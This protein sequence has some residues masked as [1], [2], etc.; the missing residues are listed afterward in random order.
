M[1]PALK[2]PEILPVDLLLFKEQVSK[3][4][5]TL[6]PFK[7]LDFFHALDDS[8]LKALLS[9]IGL[10]E[11]Q[12]ERALNTI[13]AKEPFWDRISNQALVPMANEKGQGTF[14]CRIFGMPK[15]IGAEE[16]AWFLGLLKEAIGQVFFSTKEESLFSEKKGIP[17]YLQQII[18]GGNGPLHLLELSFYRS[19][20][21]DL[22]TLK[23]QLEKL[24][25]APGLFFCGFCD[26]SFWFGLK[27][28][29][30]KQLEAGLKRALAH[31]RRQGV[32]LKRFLA[33]SFVLNQDELIGFR[34]F[35]KGF[36]AAVFAS[37]QV[38]DLLSETGLDYNDFFRILRIKSPSSSVGLMLRLGSQAKRDAALPMLEGCHFKTGL[39]ERCLFAY[40]NVSSLKTSR[41]GLEIGEYCER[42][43]SSIK[44][45]V[46][47]EV[48][49]GF[50][51]VV[52]PFVTRGN[53]AVS[54][55][56][57]LYH[58]HLLGPGNWALFDH[59]TCNVHGDILYSWGDISGAMASF[60]RGVR[61]KE[62]DVNLLNSLGACLADVSRFSK[63]KALFQRVLEVEPGNV[64]AL[65]NLSSIY[66]K[67]NRPEEA[68]EM[69]KRAYEQ[70]PSDI[71]L[72]KRLLELHINDEE[73]VDAY[74]LSRRISEGDCKCSPRLFKLCARAAMEMGK[75]Q[76][77]RELLR[78]CLEK[79]PEDKEAI[80]L[81]ARGFLDF[82]RDIETARHL[83]GRF[84]EE[85]MPKGPLKRMVSELWQRIGK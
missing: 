62:D 64:M 81:L 51:G 7:S 9:R 47:K 78:N 33:Y 72:T 41:Q 74:K 84:K 57:A 65:Y 69:V 36:K 37:H 80:M 14:L 16:G 11:R 77:A 26:A 63:A 60:R 31:F 6:F 22:N 30:E 34:D 10:S 45:A 79:G 2:H 25:R 35:S 4:L 42:L 23:G 32:S 85:D 20:F 44:R 12:Q 43:F 55:F 21:P 29:E 53:L 18:E 73:W 40:I 28:G 24:F 56:L 8:E 67:Q 27:D 3:A 52:Q 49:G 19:F 17:S 39:G 75:W 38:R 50:A 83:L 68:K 13:L 59:V 58:A 70:N 76:E 82:D 48:T 71:A 5:G 46:D 15:S 1:R 54:T 66:L 61:L